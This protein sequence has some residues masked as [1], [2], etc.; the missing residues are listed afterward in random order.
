MTKGNKVV[1]LHRKA[2]D[3]TVFYVGMGNPDRPY[4]VK[5]RNN[6]WN[7]TFNKHGLEVCVVAKD[8]STEDAYELEMF[9]ISE[10][11]RK[12]KGLGNLVNLD[13]GGAGVAGYL[14]SEYLRKT[15]GNRNSKKVINT[16]TLEVLESGVYLNK[17]YGVSASVLYCD[18]PKSDWMRLEDYNTGKHLTEML[19]NRYNIKG[20]YFKLINTNTLEIF[21]SMEA[22]C[23]FKPNE[24]EYKRFTDK[25]SGRTKNNSNVMHYKDY[26]DGLHLKEEWKNREKRTH[27][28]LNQRPHKN[29]D[30]YDF[31]KQIWFK[32]TTEEF[33]LKYKATPH[34][35]GSICK[36]RFCRKEATTFDEINSRWKDVIDLKTGNIDRFNA[37][38]LSDYLN[39]STNFLGAFFKGK[40][41][42]LYN[43]YAFIENK[44]N[45]KFFRKVLD[46]KTGLIERHNS[47]S[48]AKKIGIKPKRL[49]HFMNGL[50]KC[51]MKRYVLVD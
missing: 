23:G 9:L 24:R 30:V 51:Y 6:W 27:K 49:N 37:W 46:T 45:T 10:I 19:V 22:A 3:N 18:Y 11:G 12:D 4:V 17:K 1:Y 21:Y 15:V 43:R 26:E 44:P 36:G 41:K 2:T 20:M 42:I 34:A 5:G 31:K 48:L 33:K 35:S 14:R 38:H 29:I 39:V 47:I 25:L 7:S 13:D 8:L 40:Q 50:T 28:S 16:E 32:T